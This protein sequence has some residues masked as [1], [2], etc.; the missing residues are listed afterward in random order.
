MTPGVRP[1]RAF[2]E[3]FMPD[4]ISFDQDIVLH[5]APVTASAEPTVDELIESYQIHDA[6]E[7]AARSAKQ[8]I[9]AQ[10]AAL[11]PQNEVITTS[12]SR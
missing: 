12:P 10:L 1:R 9:A 6:A 3:I 8:Q 11:A 7:K 5:A 2:K 4:S